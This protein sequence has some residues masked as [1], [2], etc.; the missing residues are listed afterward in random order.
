MYVNRE[1]G[2]LLRFI[3]LK[4]VSYVFSGERVLDFESHNVLLFDK[5]YEV[6]QKKI[7]IHQILKEAILGYLATIS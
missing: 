3:G 2:C 7:H 1:R 4:L 5:K 6:L